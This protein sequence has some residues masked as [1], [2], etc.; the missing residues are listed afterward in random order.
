MIGSKFMKKTISIYLKNISKEYV[1]YHEKPT[2]IENIFKP[3]EYKEKFIALNN[4]NLTIY[5][6][7]KVGLVGS[8]GSGKTTLLK[9]ITG[10]ANPTQGDIK[11]YGK[12]VSL[13][14]IAAGFHG[15]MTGEENIFLNGMIIGMD[16]QEIQKKFADIIKFADIGKFIDAPLYTYSNGMKLRLGFSIAIH[17]NPDILILDEDITTGDNNFIIKSGKKLKELFKA[18]KTIIVTT[19]WIEFL[20]KNCNRILWLDSGKIIKSGGLEIIDEYLL[21]KS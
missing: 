8:N 6:G 18:N 7:E 1:L 9:L 3:R 4:I 15:D 21:K 17:S 10:I 14:D 2:L 13:I 16:R 20:K 19:H 11:T 12:I 5:K